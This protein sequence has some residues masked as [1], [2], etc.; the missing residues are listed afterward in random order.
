[1]KNILLKIDDTIEKRVKIDE[2]IATLFKCMICH[3]KMIS[4]ISI[5]LC[6]KQLRGCATCVDQWFGNNNTCPHCR[7][8]SSDLKLDC[9]RELLER[10]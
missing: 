2:V 6:C 1:M 5:S 3:D 10:H 4:P 7:T 9:F 8:E